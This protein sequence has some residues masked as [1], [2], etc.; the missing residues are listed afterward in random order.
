MGGFDPMSGFGG[1]DAGMGGGF[2][3]GDDKKGSDKKVYS[4]ATCT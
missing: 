3:G 1:Y 2:M 4:F